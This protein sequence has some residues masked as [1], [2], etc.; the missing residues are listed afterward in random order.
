MSP[1]YEPLEGLSL[2]DLT[3]KSLFLVTLATAKRVSEIQAID[4]EVGFSQGNAVCS[5]TLNFLAKNESPSNP[6]PRSF[7]IQNLSKVA[8]PQEL[9]ASLCPVRAI[10]TYLARTASIRGRSSN[11]WCSVKDPTRPLSKNALAFF[12]KELILEAH[13]HINE[14]DAR[15]V[16]SHIHEVRSIATSVAFRHN[17]SLSQIT[18]STFWRSK[19]V[20][21][22]HYL[23]EVEVAYQDL[24][25]LGPVS[26]AGL[27]LGGTH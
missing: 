19:S 13:R 3:K 17:K 14:E 6:W 16:K 12:V 8:G 21:A 27:V 23:R 10:K 18:Q 1:R 2:R 22:S 9:E 11:L 20:F 24:F 5:F 25:A 4:K 26:V 7:T 15:L